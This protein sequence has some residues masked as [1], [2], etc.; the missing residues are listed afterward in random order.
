LIASDDFT[1][2]SDQIE[3]IWLSLDDLDWLE[4]EIENQY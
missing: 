3:E 2:E 1:L 4:N